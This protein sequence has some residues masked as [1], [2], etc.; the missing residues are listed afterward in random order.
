[1]L[2]LLG[3]SSRLPDQLLK[4]NY[5]IRVMPLSSIDI[6]HRQAY[7]FGHSVLQIHFQF[8]VSDDSVYQEKRLRSDC[9]DVLAYLGCCYQHMDYPKTS[10][11]LKLYT[12]KGDNSVKLF[13]LSFERGLL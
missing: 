10:L 9:A 13:G 1:M 5:F 11:N 12:F 6:L 2:N 7:G 3:L 4:K 8:T